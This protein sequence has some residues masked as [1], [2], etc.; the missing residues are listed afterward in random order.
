MISVWFTQ[1]ADIVAVYSGLVLG[2]HPANE[3]C[4]YFATMSL[5]GWVQAYN[6]PW[7]W[8]KKDVQQVMYCTPYIYQVAMVIAIVNSQCA[9]FFQKSQKMY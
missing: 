5:I 8:K 7:Y 9:E 3:R 1:A 6:Q 4:S 2:L